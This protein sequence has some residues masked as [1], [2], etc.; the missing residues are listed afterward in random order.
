VKLPS[1]SHK[2]KFR[3]ILFVL[4]ITGV[5]IHA[6]PHYEKNWKASGILTGTGIL[7]TGAA[8]IKH[9]SVDG[10]TEEEI[11][12]LDRQDVNAFDRGATYN[13]SYSAKRASD[14][15]LFSSFL[16]PILPLVDKNMK[17]DQGEIMLMYAETLILTH[18]ITQLTK[19]VT[20]RTRPYV[21]NEEAPVDEKTKPEARYSFFSGHVSTVSALSFMTASVLNRYYRGR[22]FMPVVWTSAVVLPAATAYLR[23]RAGKHFPTDVMVGYASGAV[24]GVLVPSLHLNKKLDQYGA[25]LQLGANYFVFSMNF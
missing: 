11:A 4:L 12:L 13:Y 23:V 1:S 9:A 17:E 14:I 24:I 6:Q 16:M 22:K 5:Q 18:G 2:I 10:L 25:D 8:Y 3:S 7:A 15:I 19:K 20:M 21:Y